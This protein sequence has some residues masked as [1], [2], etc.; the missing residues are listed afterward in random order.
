MGD[1]FFTNDDATNGLTASSVNARGSIDLSKV[2]SVRVSARLNLP[3]GQ[4]G[5]ELHTPS[6]AWL[7][8]FETESEF[9]AWLSAL[10][11]IVSAN[12]SRIQ[13]LTGDD[14]LLKDISNIDLNQMD[15]KTRDL[16]N[17][18]VGFVNGVKENSAQRGQNNDTADV[19]NTD[20]TSFA[21]SKF[22]SAMHAERSAVRLR[23]PTILAPVGNGRGG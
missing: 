7:L 8:C 3:G 17:T 1:A 23:R 22:T 6:R 15:I 10:S 13:Q 4:K 12:V 16:F 11:R 19:T 9:A 20:N 21:S 5:I 14:E 18:S 2:G